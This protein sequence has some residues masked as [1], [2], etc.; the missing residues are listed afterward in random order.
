MKYFVCLESYTSWDEKYQTSFQA[1]L[2]ENPWVTAQEMSK[3]E[4]IF[5]YAKE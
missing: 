2:Y 1:I 5:Y 3:N 4:M